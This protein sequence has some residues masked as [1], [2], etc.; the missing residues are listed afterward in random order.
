MSFSIHPHRRFPVCCPVTSHAGTRL[1]LPLASCSVFWLLSMFLVLNSGPASAEW[2]LVSVVD[3][4]GVTI[5]VDPA[6]IHRKGDRVTMGELIDY[7]TIQT[8]AGTAF[9]SSKLQREYDCAGDRHRTLALTKWSGNMATG[10]EI[11]TTSEVQKWEPA[12]PGSIGK[13]LLRIACD[14]Q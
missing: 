9:L 4:A 6:T 14:K 5:Y 2:V 8:V 10:R 13:R 7:R 11:L 1:K 12:D 3:Q